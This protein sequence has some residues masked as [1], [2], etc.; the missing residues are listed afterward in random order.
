MV[1]EHINC[2]QNREIM[3][4]RQGK[5]ICKKPDNCV[6]CVVGEGERSLRY[7]RCSTRADVRLVFRCNSLAINLNR[8]QFGLY[9][10]SISRFCGLGL[11]NLKRQ[12][13]RSREASRLVMRE[14]R[15]KIV[16]YLAGELVARRMK[17]GM[18][19]L[20]YLV[21]WELGNLFPLL[22]GVISPVRLGA[23]ICTYHE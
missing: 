22:S 4:I 15:P 23:L 16:K 13:G 11:N 3:S 21:S 7:R 1:K 10:I 2:M 19:V 8:S 18:L 14:L 12:S 6:N 5:I 20:L 9:C 17:P